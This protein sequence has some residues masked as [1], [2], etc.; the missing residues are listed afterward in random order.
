VKCQLL[1]ASQLSLAWNADDAEEEVL[2]LGGII[3]LGN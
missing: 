3:V 2:V 1:Y